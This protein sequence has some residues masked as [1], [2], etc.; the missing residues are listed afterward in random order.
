MSFN[1]TVYH[2]LVASPSDVSEERKLISEVI[3]TWNENNAAH[4]QA[5]LL[6]VKW[7]THSIPELGNR[8]QAIIN[9]QLVDHCDILVGAFWT[10]LGT[11]TGVSESGSAEEIEEF[12][13]K[14][15]PV[16]LYFSSVP[17]IPDSLNIDQYGKLQTYKKKLL[18][19][20]LLESYSSLEEFRGKLERQIT[21]LIRH[22]HKVTDSKEGQE[23]LAIDT[24]RDKLN[25]FIRQVELEWESE[26]DIFS[27]ST[28]NGKYIL[29]S[30]AGG[31][32]DTLAELEGQLETNAV[33]KVKEIIRTCK[34]LQN[35]QTLLDGGKSF[36]QFW[37]IGDS[38]F[39][40]LK[41][42]LK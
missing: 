14:G 28:S 42:I 41:N 36:K 26:R 15:R 4:Y 21:A 6:P 12:R 9:K 16:M 31:L 3:H 5:V 32:I 30:L 24:S 7:E 1:A 37:D 8:P 29:Q 38:V 40:E 10:R 39:V 18:Q 22:I 25:N 20:G 11:H 33:L 2:V 27:H 34:I 13:A 35:H 19:E 23:Q 17:V